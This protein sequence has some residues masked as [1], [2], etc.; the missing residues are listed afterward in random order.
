MIKYN[1]ESGTEGECWPFAVEIKSQMP[2]I[3]PWADERCVN[4][5]IRDCAIKR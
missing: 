3:Q 4:S 5:E 1:F 2:I